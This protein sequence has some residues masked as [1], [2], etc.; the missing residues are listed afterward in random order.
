M[1]KCQLVPENAILAD[2]PCH[3]RAG[4][5]SRHRGSMDFQALV[6]PSP[7]LRAGARRGRRVDGAVG[8]LD[9]PASRTSSTMPASA[10]R[11]A[12]WRRRASGAQTAAE[13]SLCSPPR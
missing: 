9:G 12:R 13:A 6:R 2:R 10:G 5:L 1:T 8:R 7:V 3:R 4:Q 11:T